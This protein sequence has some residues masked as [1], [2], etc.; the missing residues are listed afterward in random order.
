MVSSLKLSSFSLSRLHLKASCRN[1]FLEYLSHFRIDFVAQNLLFPDRFQ[2]IRVF[3]LQMVQEQ[4]LEFAYITSLH[5][6][7]ETSHTRIKNTHLF[8]SRHRHVLLLF[9]QLSQLLASVQEMLSGS[10]Q[11]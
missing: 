5:L 8:F 7:K 2:H 6:V 10:V 1:E 4:F 3:G 11:V 9:E